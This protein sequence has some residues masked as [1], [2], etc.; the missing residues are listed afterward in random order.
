M[1]RLLDEVVPWV[2]R[3][4]RLEGKVLPWLGRMACLEGGLAR[5]PL[6]RFHASSWGSVYLDCP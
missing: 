2:S 4:A 6:G 1:A 5:T 3:V